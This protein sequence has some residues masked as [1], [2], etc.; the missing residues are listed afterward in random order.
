MKIENTKAQMR[1]G[2][3]EYCILSVLAKKPSYASDILEE[4]KNAKM[5]VVEGTL[6]PL[7]TRLKNA[8]LLGYKW[9]ESTQ[10]PPRKYYELTDLGATFLSELEVSWNELVEAVDLVKDSK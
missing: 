5:I 7:L 8:K 9:E 10:G 6:Y 2:V 1:K 3:L 4:L